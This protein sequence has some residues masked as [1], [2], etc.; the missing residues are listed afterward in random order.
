M[1]TLMNKLSKVT[2]N[3][4]AFLNVNG[5]SKLRLETIQRN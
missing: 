2:E 4:E 1:N 5:W 3:A